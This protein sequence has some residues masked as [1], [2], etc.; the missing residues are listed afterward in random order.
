MKVFVVTGWY[1]GDE[2]EVLGVYTSEA[3]AKAAIR[4]D[5]K[6]QKDNDSN[7]VESIQIEVFV[8]DKRFPWNE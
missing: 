7:P 3:K 4:I 8:V 6:W 2:R 5:N 1:G